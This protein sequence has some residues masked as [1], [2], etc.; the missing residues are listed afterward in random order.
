MLTVIGILVT[1][2]LM[3]IGNAAQ[4]RRQRRERELRRMSREAK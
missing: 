2:A 4:N 3:V 1:V